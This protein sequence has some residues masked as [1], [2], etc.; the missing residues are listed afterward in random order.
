MSKDKTEVKNSGKK[1]AV[2]L[3]F[4]QHMS[5]LGCVTWPEYKFCRTRRWRSDFKIWRP[6]NGKA[7]TDPEDCLL[8]EVEGSAWTNGRHTRGKGFIADME[9]YNVAAKLGYHVLRF[10]PQQVLSGD[11]KQFIKEFFGL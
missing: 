5:E 6:E 3:V 9:K 10:T 4:E 7:R 8:I 1:T 2:S 11:A